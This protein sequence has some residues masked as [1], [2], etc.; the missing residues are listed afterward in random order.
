MKKRFTIMLEETT[1]FRLKKLAAKRSPIGHR[2][3]LERVLDQYARDELESEWQFN[4]K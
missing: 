1:I 2:E 3:E 4:D